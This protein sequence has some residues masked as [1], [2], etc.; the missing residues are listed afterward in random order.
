[1][2][3]AVDV[4]GTGSSS[5][6][7][8]PKEYSDEEL[9]A[10]AEVIAYLARQPYS[11][12]KVG[13]VGKSWSAFNAIMFAMRRTPYVAAIYVAHGSE[14]LFFNDVHYPMGAAHFDQYIM[15]QTNEN[16][17]PRSPNYLLDSE[18]VADR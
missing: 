11:I 16:V 3:A 14:D 2:F 9:Q 8:V 15:E 12:G 17:L 1:M 5:G 18:W 4:P 13:L 7:T 6:P 10:G